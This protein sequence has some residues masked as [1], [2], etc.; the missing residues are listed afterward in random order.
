M[1]KVDI[2]DLKR[3]VPD[4]NSIG[5]NDPMNPMGMN[6]PMM[7]SSNPEP[8][9]PPVEETVE[10]PETV[11]DEENNESSDKSSEE[12][13][14]TSENNSEVS[15][16][17]E[18]DTSTEENN[19]EESVEEVKEEDDEDSCNDGSPIEDNA[20]VEEVDNNTEVIESDTTN[21]ENTELAV[22]DDNT[23]TSTT[24][25][26]PKEENRTMKIKN[27]TLLNLTYSRSNDNSVVATLSWLCND[28]E[29]NL[30]TLCTNYQL[31]DDECEF[32]EDL[33]IIETKQFVGI[34]IA[35][36]MLLNYLPKYMT[37]LNFRTEDGKL[38]NDTKRL[39]FDG[40][41]VGKNGPELKLVFEVNNS[42]FASLKFIDNYIYDK[43]VNN[44]DFSLA[45]IDA[46][47]AED[48]D[49]TPIRIIDGIESII[50]IAPA[51]K[52]N[53]STIA[54]IFK[55][56]T[57][58][59][60]DKEY[61]TILS[62]FNLGVKYP[63]SKF[64]KNTFDKMKSNF[65]GDKEEYMNNLISTVKF[66]DIEKTYMCLK[67]VNKSKEEVV[68]LLDKSIQSQLQTMIAN[69]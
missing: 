54:V 13:V 27:A 31:E 47:K 3:R 62:S 60:A 49:N 69:Y 45:V 20:E 56:F 4:A 16:D 35:T 24:E 18:T 41:K 38:T 63:K 29:D 32:V 67:A 19:E 58:R 42:L 2:E 53:K 40:V 36:R 44:Y 8:P 14:E 61:S 7:M 28:V 22:V 10:N 12:V 6:D 43:I 48:K 15:E 9:V 11:S 46:S 39:F 68:F 59:G 64:K 55:V 51:S 66:T 23:S 37:D 17:M 30:F 21:E 33:E 5:Y 52:K 50:S 25:E 34:R 26:P 57:Y 1:K 65:Y